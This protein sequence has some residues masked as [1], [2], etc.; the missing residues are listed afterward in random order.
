MAINNK[1]VNKNS[2]S[3][4]NIS[5][6][7]YQR[8]TSRGLGHSLGG[9]KSRLFQFILRMRLC[10]E[11][12]FLGVQNVDVVRQCHAGTSLAGGVMRQHNFHFDSEY[13]CRKK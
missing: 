8:N 12:F 11:S 13:S 2:I 1:R 7:L 3:F 10:R 5:L 6:F 4:R 9:G